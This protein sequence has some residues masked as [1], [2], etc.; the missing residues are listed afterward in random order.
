MIS[1]MGNR[2]IDGTRVFTYDTLP[3]SL[4]HAL[5]GSA[6]AYA[7]KTAIVTDEGCGYSYGQFLSMVDSFAGYLAERHAV[8]K[9]QHIAL[10]FFNDIEFC[11]SLFALIRLGAVAV[12]IP[13]KY[14]ASEMLPLVEMA[15]VDMILCD[16]VFAA[17]FSHD[18]FT[19]IASQPGSDYGFAGLAGSA[20][21][22]PDRE[23]KGCLADDALVMFTSGTTSRSK[24]VLLKNYNIMHAVLAY[25]RIFRIT[26][27]DSSVIPIPIYTITGTVALL[28]LFVFSGGIVFLHKRFAADRVLECVRKNS[29]T[30][31]HASPT[32]F[33]LLLDH[34]DEFPELPS[35]RLFACGSSNMPVEN[36]RKLKHWI[37]S[38]SFHTVYGLTETSSPAT[39]FPADAATSEFIGASGIPIPGV[40]VKIIDEHEKT[41]PAGTIGEIVLRGTVVIHHYMFGGADWFTADG[42]LKTGDLGYMNDY[43]YLYVVDRKKDM[44]NR[45][46]EKICSFDVENALSEIPGISETAVIGIP[47][48]VYGEVPVAVVRKEKNSTVTEKQINEYL[49]SRIAKY[50]VPTHIYFVEQ[51]LKTKNGKIDKKGL[52]EV[53]KNI[54]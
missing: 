15:H 52:R 9:G 18:A 20:S 14:T 24:G 4:Y 34:R 26:D 40:E 13:S 35:I 36:I 27:T 38:A 19:V 25:S 5:A 21:G 33:S 22:T 12:I 28:G 44:I 10:V 49:T 1:D 16:F 6:V 8:R 45:G 29:I 41:M 42:W 53:L 2:E 37:P 54:S 32:V 50:M 46:G 11:V 47:D 39:I 30:L 51:I 23:S 48:D 17:N 7:D 3:Q 43:G 31:I